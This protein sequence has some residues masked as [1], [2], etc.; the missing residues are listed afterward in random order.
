MK[1]SIIT[2][3]YNSEKC[4]EKTLKSVLSQTFMNYEYYIFDGG[5]TDRTLAI[6][7][8]FQNSFNQ[9]M[10]YT[11]QTDQGIY[12]AMNKSLSCITGDY[13]LFLNADDFYSSDFLQYLS[14]CINTNPADVYFGDVITYST[15][16]IQ[17]ISTA[18]L[19]YILTGMP[20]C[21]QGVA[22]KTSL[23]KNAQGFD[24]TFKI[25]ADWDLILR[26][27]LQGAV[28]YKY[29]EPKVFYALGGL[30]SSDIFQHEIKSIIDKN[31][32]HPFNIDIEDFINFLSK[33][34]LLN[35]NTVKVILSKI[36]SSNNQVLKSVFIKN[37]VYLVLHNYSSFWK[38]TT[39]S[40]GYKIM[41]FLRSYRR[42]IDVVRIIIK[43][44]S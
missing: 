26:L 6:L 25:S 16:D 43:P 2:V 7:D 42:L 30:S 4:I 1:F 11:S 44:F 40:K 12:N 20:M 13:V 14:T 35:E 31:L 34:Y 23:F 41:S 8:D 9:K 38:K 39:T 5:S 32:A 36:Y 15:D 24:E 22:I 28:F 17:T 29:T 19:D 37:Y 10:L 27:Y 18:N 3:C 21:H 33:P